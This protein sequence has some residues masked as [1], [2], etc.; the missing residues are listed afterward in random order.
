MFVW[1]VS[2]ISDVDECSLPGVCDAAADCHNTNGSF[3][4]VCQ[5]GYSGNGFKC[6][7]STNANGGKQTVEST[8]HCL[9][10]LR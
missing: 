1:K 9:H 8:F 10:E 6:V 5:P 4:C 7:R 3:T 2:C